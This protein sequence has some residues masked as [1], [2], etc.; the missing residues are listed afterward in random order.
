MSEFNQVGIVS[1]LV[2]ENRVVSLNW[3]VNSECRIVPQEAF[4]SCRVVIA[5]YFIDD[6]GVRLEGTKAV[7]KPDWDVKLGEIIRR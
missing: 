3:P 2:R 4:F 5:R 6:F 7:C 1:V